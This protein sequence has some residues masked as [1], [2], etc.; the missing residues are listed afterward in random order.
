MKQATIGAT[1]AHL[2]SRLLAAQEAH[3]AQL[4]EKQLGQF[5]ADGFGNLR[6]EYL[7]ADNVTYLNHASIGTIP[8]PVN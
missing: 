3:A 1:G 7:L 2:L 8:R 5:A 4:A 6:K